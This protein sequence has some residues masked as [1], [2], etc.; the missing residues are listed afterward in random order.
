MLAGANS[1]RDAARAAVSLAQLPQEPPV[2]VRSGKTGDFNNEELPQQ[3]VASLNHWHATLTRFMGGTS[4]P[5]PVTTV[6]VTGATA[7][8]AE[9]SRA[10]TSANV[11]DGSTTS[12]PS[13]SASTGTY[14]AVWGA[15]GA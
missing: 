6:T 10:F 3:Q 7:N 8:E 5:A 1:A 4:V 14:A 9:R 2:P 15:C 12:S 13:A 11:R